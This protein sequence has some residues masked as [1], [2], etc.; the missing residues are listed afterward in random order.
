MLGKE[1]PYYPDEFAELFVIGQTPIV[2][3]RAYDA[4]Q[5]W[6]DF[7]KGSLTQCIEYDK[8]P[9]SLKEITEEDKIELAERSLAPCL[10]ASH[11]YREMY[12]V[13]GAKKFS[14]MPGIPQYLLP[15]REHRRL[16][17]R[18]YESLKTMGFP[19]FDTT[20]EGTA[21]SLHFHED[22]RAEFLMWCDENCTGFY[23][24]DGTF[25]AFQ[26]KLEGFQAKLAFD[27]GT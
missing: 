24:I 26:K 17:R 1:I 10:P 15:F 16:R 2:M 3:R 18:V 20:T 4:N 19:G 25:A 11:M 22:R 13:E 23:Y 6:F 8:I 9:I 27:V 21:I 12:I 7:M 5:H 14:G